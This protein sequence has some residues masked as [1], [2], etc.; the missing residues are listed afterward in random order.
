MDLKYL[1]EKLIE[2]RKEKNT[3]INEQKWEEAAQ[4]R[5]YERKLI[6]LI[7]ELETNIE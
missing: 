6:K 4:F 2:V 5:D 1:E 7:E 3:L